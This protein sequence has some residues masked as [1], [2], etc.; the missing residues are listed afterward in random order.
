MLRGA[1]NAPPSEQRTI[2]LYRAAVLA[3][4]GDMNGAPMGKVSARELSAEHW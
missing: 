4:H 2:K 1:H 3:A